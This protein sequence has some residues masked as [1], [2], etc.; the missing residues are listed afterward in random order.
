MTLSAAEIVKLPTAWSSV[1]PNLIVPCPQC[2]K[3]KEA[4]L[5]ADMWARRQSVLK[6][7]WRMQPNSKH[8]MMMLAS[9]LGVSLPHI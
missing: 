3:S 2:R 4:E 1:A 6:K 9:P 7:N 5:R 8:N